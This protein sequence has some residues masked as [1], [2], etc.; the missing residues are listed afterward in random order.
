M[1]TESVN[2]LAFTSI[3]MAMVIEQAGK[4]ELAKI[5]LVM[6]F[7]THSE[8]LSYL[9]HGGTKI[10]GLDKLIIDKLPYFSNFNKRYY[11]NLVTSINAVQFLVEVD[12]ISIENNLVVYNKKIEYEKYMGTRLN[13]VSKA[14][15]NLSKILS[16]D[17]SNL[18]LSLR[19]EL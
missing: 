15:R 11:D 14:S 6:P 16:E 9:A 4:L 3:A 8:L 7:L 19:V 2:N 12:V 18:Y 13:K 10:K 1:R 17:I 5:L